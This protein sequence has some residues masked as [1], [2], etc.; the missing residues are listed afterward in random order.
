MVD[1]S[2]FSNRY[3]TGLQQVHRSPPK[4]LSEDQKSAVHEDSYKVFRLNA[5]TEFSP[6]SNFPQG[7]TIQMFP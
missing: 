1:C 5:T 3:P 7:D 6:L 2:V 4:I